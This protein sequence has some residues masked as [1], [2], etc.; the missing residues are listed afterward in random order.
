MKNSTIAIILFFLVSIGLTLIPFLKPGLFDVHDPTSA[1]RLYTLVQTLHAGQFPAA[2]TNLLNFGFGYPLHIYYAPLFGYLGALIFPLFQSYEV[3]IKVVLLIGSLIGTCGIYYLLTQYGKSAAILG[4]VAYTFLPY[5]ASAL[6]VRGSYAEFFAMSLLPWVL[7]AWR[8]PQNRRHTIAF[9]ALVTALFAL[10]HNTLPILAAPIICL[11]LVLFQRKSVSGSLITSILSLGLSAWFIIPVLF[12]KSFVQVDTIARLT[13]FHDHFVA[14]PQ[15][16]YSPWGYGGS[17]PGVVNDHMSF[18]IGKGQLLLALFGSGVLLWRKHWRNLILY[19]TIILFATYLLLDSSNFL[20]EHV[21]LLSIMQFPWRTLAVVGVGVSVLAGVSIST[22]PS[23][24]RMPLSI[25]LSLLIIYSN[26]RYFRPQE[27]RMYNNDILS[28][29]GNLD[30]LV[31][32]KIPEY[33]PQWMPTFPNAR[34][35]D[36]LTRTA[37]TVFGTVQ[38]SDPSPVII[39]TAYMPQWD[40][41]IDGAH[42]PIAPTSTGRITT[43]TDMSAGNKTISLTWHRTRVENISLAVSAVS[44]IVVIGL[45]VL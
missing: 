14:I 24:W 41:Q 36:G 17:A 35:D 34:Q 38:L 21:S 23:K 8:F 22:F 12:E 9:T 42:V 6:Y 19:C 27:Y 31:R 5:R 18:M 39:Q 37:T 26:W 45:L 15:L 3:V 13:N 20:W 11:M 16:W 44:I 4:A 33:L 40:L 32:E 10:S 30:P 43:T 2:W 28:S 29:M 7:Y 25:V 1:F